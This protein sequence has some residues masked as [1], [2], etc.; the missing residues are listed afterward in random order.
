[1][2]F[3][4]LSVADLVFSVKNSL[5]SEF[6]QLVVE[7]EVSNI[8]KTV[9]GHIYFT[10][11]D[12]RASVSCALFRG[13]AMRNAQAVRKLKDGD[14]IIVSGS[15]GVYA[16]RGV[17]QIIAKRVAP[18]G[19]GNLALQFELLKEKLAAK[20]LFDASHKKSIPKYP[21]RIAVITAP[22]GAALQDFL[23]VMKRR[24][25]WHDIVI[26]PAVVQG[27]AS[28]A[29]LVNALNA[30]AKV[31]G[32]ET[33]VL[34]RGGG[35]MEDLWSFNDERL[36]EAIF[37]CPIPTISAVGHEVDTTLSDY[38]A[39]LRLETPSAAAEYLS[40]SHTQTSSRLKSAGQTLK[41]LLFQHQHQLQ[42]R[43]ERINPVSLARG[44]EMRLTGFRHRLARVELLKNK[45]SYVRISELEQ[46]SSELLERALSSAKEAL[47]DR[48]LRV[49]RCGQLLAAMDPKNVLNRGYCYVE[50]GNG[51]VLAKF[52]EYDK[53]K[54]DEVFKIHFSDGKGL[55]ARK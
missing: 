2:N 44:L 19:K 17:F 24:T 35:A 42:K 51:D 55:A 11:S 6:R 37:A 4:T 46:Q 31:Q 45:K 29:S 9:A 7:G 54:K 14:H 39:D 1:M 36:I 16:K 30:A 33:I 34:T 27:E 8:S 5:E 49:D 22:Y 13:D 52:S 18:A 53:L 38:A 15:I 41:G 23:Q 32:V 20:G 25:L 50:N 47:R 28:A 26:V 21:K 10:L 48:A 3:K 12:D 40:Q 43:L